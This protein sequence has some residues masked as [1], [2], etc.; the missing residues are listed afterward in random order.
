MELARNLAVQNKKQPLEACVVLIAVGCKG[1]E[2]VDLLSLLQRFAMPVLKP[3]ELT[4]IDRHWAR[5]RPR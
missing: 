2:P 3:G 1:A 5:L 4:T